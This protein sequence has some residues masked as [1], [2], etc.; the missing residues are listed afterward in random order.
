MYNTVF[1]CLFASNNKCCKNSLAPLVNTWAGGSTQ[2]PLYTGLGAGK[3]RNYFQG[4]QVSN[5][6]TH[7]EGEAIDHTWTRVKQ[8]KYQLRIRNP[9]VLTST[10]HP[11]PF[12]PITTSPHICISHLTSTHRFSPCH[13]ILLFLSPN[14]CIFHTDSQYFIT[15]TIIYFLFNYF[16]SPQV[17]RCQLILSFEPIFCLF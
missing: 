15:L 6:S 5:L 2:L 7:Q 17:P 10:P 9:Q 1:A 8:H 3:S 14:F 13:L 12:H 4:S 16:F 11:C